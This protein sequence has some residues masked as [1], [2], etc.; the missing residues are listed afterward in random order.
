MGG[1]GWLI[2]VYVMPVKTTGLLSLEKGISFEVLWKF[3]FQ[4]PIFSAGLSWKGSYLFYSIAE[5]P[6]STTVPG[7]TGGMQSYLLI[8]TVVHIK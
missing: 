6:A 2:S 7:H 4:P 8:Y 5:E 3:I 1:C